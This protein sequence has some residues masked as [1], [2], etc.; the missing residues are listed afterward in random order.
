MTS[1]DLRSR[2]SLPNSPA[3]PSRELADKVST[4]NRP[5][6]G[7]HVSLQAAQHWSSTLPHALRTSWRW[8]SLKT[9][10]A[11]KS[12]LDLPHKILEPASR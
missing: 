9:V 4:S 11:A 2:P 10:G 3:E 8:P 1:F 12:A 6:R 5:R 7:C